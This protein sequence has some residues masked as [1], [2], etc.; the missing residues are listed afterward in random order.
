MALRDEDYPNTVEAT[1]RVLSLP[2]HPYLKEDEQDGVI[3]SLL[4]VLA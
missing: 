4:E 3:N 2:I 1:R